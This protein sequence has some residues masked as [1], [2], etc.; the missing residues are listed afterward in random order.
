VIAVSVATVIGGAA[1]LL[2]LVGLG[3]RITSAAFDREQL[4]TG[5]RWPGHA[6]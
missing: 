1:L 4:I 2:V 3:W 6:S 5:T